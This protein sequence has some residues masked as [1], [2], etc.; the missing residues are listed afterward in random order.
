MYIST[1]ASA[2]KPSSQSLENQ[3]KD[4]TKDELMKVGP[5][6]PAKDKEN[7]VDTPKSQKFTSIKRLRYAPTV[8]SPLL[9]DI[10]DMW[11]N[12]LKYMI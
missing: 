11:F 8:D 2:L 12:L 9:N 7:E 10:T 4:A 1:T 6:T 5:H 3:E